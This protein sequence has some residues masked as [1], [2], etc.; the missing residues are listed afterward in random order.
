MLLDTKSE[1]ARFTE[2]AAQQLVLLHLQA[3]LQKLHSLLT[4]DGDVA[5]DLLVTPDAE[6]TNSVPSCTFHEHELHESPVLRNP[7]QKT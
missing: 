6:G 2:V 1:A 3:T 4:T 5:C 7:Q